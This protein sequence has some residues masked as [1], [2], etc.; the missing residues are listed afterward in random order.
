MNKTQKKSALKGRLI[1]CVALAVILVFALALA[2][3]FE[4]ARLIH[5]A[6]ER[7]MRQCRTIA[8]AMFQYANDHDGKYP[9]GNSSTEVF[10]K[11]IDGNYVS[12][13]TL[14]YVPLAGK[15]AAR[16]G[17]RLKPENVSF[18]VT[19]GVGENAPDGLPVTYLTGYKVDYQPGGKAV[20][21]TAPY[22]PYGVAPRTWVQWW[23]G[24]TTE[25]VGPYLI[26]TYRSNSAFGKKLDLPPSG[27]GYVRDFISK[28][29]DAHGNT[30]RQLTPN[31]PLK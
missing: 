15:S 14:F 5:F 7:E 29:F 16:P 10:Q 18:D 9:D 4:S 1:F 20:A 25:S 2:V 30:Y 12:D 13:P 17:E 22:P 31:G 11:L 3:P 27:N 19:G 26:V 24:I 28:D 21:L 23:N 8:L 6:G